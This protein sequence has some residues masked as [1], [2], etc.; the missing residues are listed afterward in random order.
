MGL[1][2][3]QGSLSHMLHFN[4]VPNYSHVQE[5]EKHH[6]SFLS[7]EDNEVCKAL[8]CSFHLSS[9]LHRVFPSLLAVHVHMCRQGCKYQCACGQACLCGPVSHVGAALFMGPHLWPTVPS[10]NLALM[11]RD[12]LLYSPISLPFYP[13]S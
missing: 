11:C 12:G 2:K 8:N 9:F 7:V 3:M 1:V 10:V 4:R 6:S 13:C 5:S